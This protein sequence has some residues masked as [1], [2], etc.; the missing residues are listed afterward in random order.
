M[1]TPPLLIIGSVAIDTIR[2]PHGNASDQL[3]GSATF[4]A[5]TAK[6]WCGPVIVSAI[7]GDFPVELLTRLERAG[8]DL[9][10]LTRDAKGK[11]FRWTGVYSESLGTRETIGLELGVMES[12]KLRVPENIS[13]IRFAI[14]ST[15][16]PSRELEVL[17]LLHKDC[18]VAL[19]TIAVYINVPELRVQLDKIVKRADLLC[20]DQTELKQFTGL[21]DEAAAVK[22]IFSLGPRW[23]VIKYGKRGSRLYAPD[24]RTATLGI[25][26]NVP[27]DTTGAGDTFLAG[28]MAH[29]ASAGKVEFET[30]L[31]GMRLGTAAASITTEAFGIEEI[32]KA[33]KE[34]I[35]R[36]ARSVPSSSGDSSRVGLATNNANQKL[37]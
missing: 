11:S 14:I 22:K 24:G 27:K 32:I 35:E 3:G 17:P 25:Y 2:T 28:I 18:F 12:A 7:G 16:A 5:L 30:L 8:L 37:A 26:D 34:E 29:V 21:D 36:R 1:S 13:D 23:A 19:D 15:Y 10:T 6:H 20:I 9:S 33:T 4:A 31:E